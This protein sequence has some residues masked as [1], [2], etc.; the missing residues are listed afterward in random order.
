MS[1]MM[2]PPEGERPRRT[3]P[4]VIVSDGCRHWGV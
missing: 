1:Q 2:L 4:F 3:V